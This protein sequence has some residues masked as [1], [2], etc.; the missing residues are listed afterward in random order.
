[1]LQ[2]INGFSCAM[3]DEKEEFMI[4]FVQRLPMIKDGNIQEEMAAET[5]SSIV[6]RK[7]VAEQLYDALKELLEQNDAEEADR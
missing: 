4:N 2:Y 6:M 3:D 1:M 7:A 5:V